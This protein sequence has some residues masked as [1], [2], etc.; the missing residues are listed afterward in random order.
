MEQEILSIV[1]TVAEIELS[2]KSKIKPSL[3]PIVKRSDEAYALLYQTWDKNRI[4]LAE[5]FKVMLVNRASR[6]LGICSLTIGTNVG[7]VADPKQ[8]FIVALKA[9]APNIIIAHNHPSGSTT[10]SQA[11]HELTQ[12]MKK[13]GEILNVKVLDHII[14]TTEGFYSFADEGTL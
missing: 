11:D 7:T 13:A 4:E 6:V 10:P 2:Y 14:V 1:N 9:N 8:V 5:E 12:R 3:R